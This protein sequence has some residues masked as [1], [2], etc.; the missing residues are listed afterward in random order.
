M[1]H[2]GLTIVLLYGHKERENRALRGAPTKWT[3]LREAKC[4]KGIES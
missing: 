2:S 3:L 1:G 4:M